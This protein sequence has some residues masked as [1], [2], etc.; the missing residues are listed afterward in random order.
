MKDPRTVEAKIISTSFNSPS[1]RW[2]SIE[3]GHEKLK[4]ADYIAK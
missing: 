1:E 2:E 4:L 3:L